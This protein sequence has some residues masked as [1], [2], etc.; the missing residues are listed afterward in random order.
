M[1]HSQLGRFVSRDP[2]GYEAGELNLQSYV[3]ARPTGR[4]DPSG[5]KCLVCKW[6]R[7]WQ[8]ETIASLD[9]QVEGQPVSD[10]VDSYLNYLNRKPGH[11]FRAVCDKDGASTGCEKRRRAESGR[12]NAGFHCTFCGRG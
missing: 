3:S 10:T 2:L 4:T 1:Y 6:Y 12:V 7:F 9:A 8:G 5:L 11:V